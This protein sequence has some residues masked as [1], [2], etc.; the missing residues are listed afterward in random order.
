MIRN[1]GKRIFT[2]LLITSLLLTQYMLIAPH[3]GGGCSYA[4][5]D[6]DIRVQYESWRE[7]KIPV[8]ATFSAAELSRM[9]GEVY[10]Y[11]NVTDVAPS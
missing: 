3:L 8:K 10:Y 5:S 6:V 11:T 7:D 1:T 2:V 4:A 9:E